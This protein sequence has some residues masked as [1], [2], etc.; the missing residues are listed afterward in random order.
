MSSLCGPTASVLQCLEG[1]DTALA[2]SGASCVDAPVVRGTGDWSNQ[3]AARFPDSLAQ[4]WAAIMASA[5]STSSADGGNGGDA[6]PAPSLCPVFV[7]DWLLHSK[8]SAVGDGLHQSIPVL[9][10]STSATPPPQAG[11]DRRTLASP[12]PLYSPASQAVVDDRFGV[13]VAGHVGP[14]TFVRSWFGMVRPGVRMEIC[15]PFNAT[16]RVAFAEHTQMLLQVRCV[17]VCAS[18]RASV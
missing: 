11:V 4:P 9:V 3:L 15:P 16:F 17:C 6:A 10:S 12:P 7:V 13:A 5:S 14:S 2:S 8:D 1:I 18:K